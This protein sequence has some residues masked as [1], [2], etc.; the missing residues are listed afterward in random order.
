MEGRRLL[1]R[2]F[3]RWGWGL[4]KWGAQADCT[5]AVR[6]GLQQGDA[7]RLPQAPGQLAGLLHQHVDGD[8]GQ[9]E[10]QQLVAPDSLRWVALAVV[11]HELPGEGKGMAG[12]VNSKATALPAKPVASPSTVQTRSPHWAQHTAGKAFPTPH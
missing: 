7:G 12:L 6:P 3:C 2:G 8:D 4:E 5:R 11:T 1:L 9:V 10:G